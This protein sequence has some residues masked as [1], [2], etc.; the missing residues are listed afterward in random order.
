MHLASLLCALPIRGVHSLLSSFA[1]HVDR[2]ST[3]RVQ[4]PPLLHKPFMKTGMRVQLR[5]DWLDTFRGSSAG[6][7]TLRK[8]LAATQQAADEAAWKPAFLATCPPDGAWGLVRRTLAH[9]SYPKEY[10]GLPYLSQ[11]WMRPPRC[12]RAR[13]FNACAPPAGTR[14]L[15]HAACCAQARARRHRVA[16]A[17]RSG[18]RDVCHERVAAQPRLRYNGRPRRRGCAGHTRAARGRRH[19][20]QD[21]RARSHSGA[22]AGTC[23]A[24]VSKGAYA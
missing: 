5:L 3:C 8:L 6:R 22:D 18:L 12:G 1:V 17:A 23:Q 19:R 10:L 7:K 24:Y 2:C 9:P 15:T 20:R 4:A 16:A 13:R 21:R 14:P 11:G